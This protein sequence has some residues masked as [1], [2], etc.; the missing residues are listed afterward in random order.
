MYK[1]YRTWH[2]NYKLANKNNATRIINGE[3]EILLAGLLLGAVAGGA[4]TIGFE[5]VVVVLRSQ[6]VPSAEENIEKHVKIQH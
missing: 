3:E 2:L 5:V 1:H 4:V 6:G